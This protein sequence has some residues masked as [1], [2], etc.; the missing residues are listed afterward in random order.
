MKPKWVNQNQ[1][2]NTGMSPNIVGVNPDQL[3]TKQGGGYNWEMTALGA[4]GKMAKSAMEDVRAGKPINK[5][6]AVASVIG[7]ENTL[8]AQRALDFGKNVTK[9]KKPMSSTEPKDFGT[10]NRSKQG[11]KKGGKRRGGQ[12]GNG[13]YVGGD[14]SYYAGNAMGGN[15][16]NKLSSVTPYAVT[17]PGN[18]IEI[19]TIN[20]GSLY[21][22]PYQEQ[23]D[24]DSVVVEGDYGICTNKTALRI[25]DLKQVLN[26]AQTTAGYTNPIIIDGAY[27]IFGELKMEVNANTNGG[28]TVTKNTFTYAKFWNYIQVT[29]YAHA[30]LCELESRM[31]WAPEVNESNMVVRDMKNMLTSDP[32]LFVSRNR[33]RDQLTS[34]ALPKDVMNYY[35]KIFSPYKKSPVEGGPVQLYMSNTL[36]FDIGC[37]TTNT[38]VGSFNTTKNVIEGLVN[39]MRTNFDEF[40][41]ITAL[42]MEKTNFDYVSQRYRMGAVD[43]PCY[44]NVQ[45][46]IFNNLPFHFPLG[47]GSLHYA[48][49]GTNFMKYND[50]V[51]ALPMDAGNVPI[52]LT[53]HLL[54]LYDDGDFPF[55]GENLSDWGPDFS[56]LTEASNMIATTDSSSS[57]SYGFVLKVEDRAKR[58]CTDHMV[59]LITV[60]QPA[61]ISETDMNLIPK[62]LNVRKY[63]PSK[64]SLS[65]ACVQFMYTLFGV[66]L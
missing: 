47:D 38:A 33:L 55:F 22:L 15:P 19:P 27:K 53:S 5:T 1:G 56:E 43:R 62:G 52:Y 4:G 26:F 9:G 54:S 45:N 30:L 41:Q 7:D 35:M 65:T 24:T 46:G 64:D 40:A 3:P 28:N 20:D 63:Q 14:N 2:T 49:G 44:D 59:S 21:Y 34:L 42:L 29:S 37:M 6:K 16:T 32:E 17:L 36:A 66:D 13:A 23:R 11:R 12:Q 60:G 51:I 58:Q 10:K 48:F 61:D 31:T 8:I 39:T 18:K 25:I 57:N 50:P